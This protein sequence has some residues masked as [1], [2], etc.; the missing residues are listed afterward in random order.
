MGA[1]ILPG[2]IFAVTVA[3]GQR[4]R[5]AGALIALGH[6]LI[7]IPLIL[8]I[9]LG[10]ARFLTSGPP[11]IIIGF[12]GGAMLILM[13]IQLYRGRK[14]PSSDAQDSPYSSFLAGV[15][16]TGSNPYFFLWW[17]TIG[18]GLI[19]TASG[20]GLMGLLLFWMIH[21]F[22]DLVWSLFVSEAT[23]RTRYFLSPRVHEILFSLCSAALIVF[24]LRFILSVV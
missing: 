1:I 9:S 16:A 21:W 7:E 6:G 10:F 23:Y 3:K 2:P 17:A 18:T 11:R 15:I 4:D 22:C 19:L 5:R 14:T 13:G 8:L 12:A 20:F 24:G